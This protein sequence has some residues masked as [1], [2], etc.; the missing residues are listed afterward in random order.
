MQSNFSE[1]NINLKHFIFT[2]IYVLHHRIIPF[3][4]TNA[5]EP[6]PPPPYNQITRNK[7]L[8]SARRGTKRTLRRTFFNSLV[9]AWWTISDSLM[10]LESRDTSAASSRR[11]KHRFAGIAG[12]PGI[13]GW[14]Y[15]VCIWLEGIIWRWGG[16]WHW[17]EGY[18]ILF[19]YIF[20]FEKNMLGHGYTEVKETAF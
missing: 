16:P 10:T 6:T 18:G 1:K 2:R 15:V 19:V 5:L 3:D 4:T 11:V 7:E 13:W 8:I 14:C 12:K 20:Y 17:D 9:W